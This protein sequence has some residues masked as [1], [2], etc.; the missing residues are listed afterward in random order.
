MTWGLPSTG[1]RS[2][3]CMSAP[4][5]LKGFG[6]AGVIEIVEDHQSGTDR[7]IYT[8][9]FADAVYV[10]HAFQKKS[11]KGIKT[12][13]GDIETVK[14]RLKIAEEQSKQSLREA[15]DGKGP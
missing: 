4:S 10:L 12:D 8:V 7:A 9:R 11:R 3:P 2:A 15:T 13:A 6:G 5:P 14:R 1:R